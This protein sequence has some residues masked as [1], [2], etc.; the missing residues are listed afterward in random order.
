MPFDGVGSL[1]RLTDSLVLSLGHF[2]ESL[3]HLQGGLVRG[4]QFSAAL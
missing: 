2:L 4:L 3:R 1:K